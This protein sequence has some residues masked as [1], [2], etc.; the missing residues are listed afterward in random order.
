MVAGPRREL[1]VA[2][3]LQLAPHSRLIERDRKFVMEPLNQVNQAPANDAVDRRDRGLTE[4]GKWGLGHVG[5]T[6]DPNTQGFDL[7][8]GYNCQW[9]AHNHY[10]RFLWRN[11]EKVQYPG[12][13]GKSLKGKTHS[14]D[15]FTREALQA[16]TALQTN[17]EIM[18][19]GGVDESNLAR[20]KEWGYSSVAVLGAVWMA[21]NPLEKV[22]QLKAICQAT[23]PVY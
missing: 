19:L 11:A 18:A 7:F 4:N 8:F 2:Q 22:K 6:G 23:V 16:I 9:H 10:P 21:D 14:Q 20:L 12:N 3:F 17:S 13:D 1:D 5:T 15:E